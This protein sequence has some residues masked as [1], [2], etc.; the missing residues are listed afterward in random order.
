M[1][2]QNNVIITY[3][4]Y[5]DEEVEEMKKIFNIIVKTLDENVNKFNDIVLNEELIKLLED[6]KNIQEEINRTKRYNEFVLVFGK[7]RIRFEDII[8]VTCGI[9]NYSI[10]T[11]DL[12]NLIKFINFEI[13]LDRISL[14]YINDTL[15]RIIQRIE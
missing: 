9:D 4:D 14:N 13:I 6:M 12:E 5:V 11:E 2:E 10:L 1:Y 15:L 8:D 7:L 3:S